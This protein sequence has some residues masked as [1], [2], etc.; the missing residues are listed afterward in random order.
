MQGKL[1]AQARKNFRDYKIIDKYIAGMVLTGSEIKSLRN[2]QVSIG[3]AY[4]LPQ[5]QKELYIINMHIAAYK[6]S[7]SGSSAKTD[8]RKKKGNYSSKKE[9]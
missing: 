7:H 4:V 9:K 8:T 6:Y 1:I 5:Q 2:H 3:E